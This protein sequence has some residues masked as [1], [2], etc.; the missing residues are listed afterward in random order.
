[1]N[2][3]L[4]AMA[5]VFKP[6][7]NE[8]DNSRNSQQFFAKNTNDN[9]RQKFG[10]RFGSKDDTNLRPVLKCWIC[11]GNHP[12]INCNQKNVGQP[13]NFQNSSGPTRKSFPPCTFCSKD[14]HR[15]ENCFRNPNRID[16]QR[17]VQR[18]ALAVESNQQFSCK[19]RNL[20]GGES[21][22]QTQGE[23]NNL[24]EIGL[25]DKLSPRIYPLVK[26]II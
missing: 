6:K 14:N 12:T 2:E 7:Q 18:V 23:L 5:T 11:G 17:N 26:P 21:Q 4:N 15:S 24:D 1:V 13:Q 8:F 20:Q 25:S 9:R 16:V 19:Y 3:H 22:T 10:N